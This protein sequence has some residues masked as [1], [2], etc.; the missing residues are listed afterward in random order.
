MDSTDALFPSLIGDSS[1]LALPEPVRQLHGA[2]PYVTARGEA[3]VEGDRN[4]ALRVLRR[5][6]GL[7]SPGMRQAL[8]F[9]ITRRGYRETWTR[10]FA[11][12][13]MQ[14][15]LD[16]DAEKP[17]LRERLGPITLYFALRHDIG[18]IDWDLHH[19]SA[20]GVPVPR[21]CLGQVLSRSSAKEGRYIF[22]IDARL[23]FIGRL[24]AYRGW[25]EMVPDV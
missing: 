10:R 4:L 11:S 8:E 3:D 7:P 2:T 17:F 23:P 24:V 5:L 16:R 25:L 22:A 14:S 18:G 20:F 12:G 6:L 15:V 19:V 9:S 1:W 21:S 13:D